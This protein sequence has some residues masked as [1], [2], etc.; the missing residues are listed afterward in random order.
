MHGIRL[1]IISSKYFI[2]SLQRIFY[3]LFQTKGNNYACGRARTLSFGKYKE[4]SKIIFWLYE[5]ATIY[6]DRKFRNYEQIFKVMKNQ[7]N[8]NLSVRKFNMFMS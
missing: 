2:K 4:A 3:Q 8:N 6:L 7:L 5:G 1:T